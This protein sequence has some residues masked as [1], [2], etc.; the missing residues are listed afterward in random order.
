MRSPWNGGRRSL[1]CTMCCCSSR[2][3]TE[4]G[5][6]TGR[7]IALA[8]P[9][10]NTLVAGED[11]AHV[12]GVGEHHPGALLRDAHAEDVPV[13]LASALEEGPGPGDPSD[14]LECPRH[15]RSRGKLP[16]LLDHC[17]TALYV[18]L[19]RYRTV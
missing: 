2:S 16:L 7:R 11:L 5:P 6:T 4:L 17:L 3:S 9:A 8:S 10:W 1:R 12:L 15:P 18:R 13:A 14:R 19:I